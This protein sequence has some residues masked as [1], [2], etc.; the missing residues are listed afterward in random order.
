MTS[1]LETPVNFSSHSARARAR[2][3]PCHFFFPSL[4]KF[5]IK[6]NPKQPEKFN[7]VSKMYLLLFFPPVVIKS[8]VENQQNT[9]FYIIVFTLP[10]RSYYVSLLSLYLVCSPYHKQSKPYIYPQDQNK[11]LLEC[12]AFRSF[13]LLAS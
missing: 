1:L 4:L 10:I 6:K 8:Q 7:V 9:F 3:S 13:H 11:S 12:Q 2:A 5:I